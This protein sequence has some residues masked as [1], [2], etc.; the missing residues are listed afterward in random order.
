M[1]ADDEVKDV[2]GPLKRVELFV[3]VERGLAQ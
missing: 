1:L 2:A 3:S